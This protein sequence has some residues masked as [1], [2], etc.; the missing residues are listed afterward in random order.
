[1]LETKS[2]ERKKLICI[3]ASHIAAGR[4][5]DYERGDLKRVETQITE[6]CVDLALSIYSYVD[7]IKF[8]PKKDK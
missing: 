6:Q 5:R 3:M 7:G 2:Q 1:M 8:P 4:I